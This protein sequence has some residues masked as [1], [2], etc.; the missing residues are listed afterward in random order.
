MLKVVKSW[1]T[2]T[3]PLKSKNIPYINLSKQLKVRDLVKYAQINDLQIDM[4]SLDWET[5]II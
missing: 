3:H 5:P 1:W 2:Q 4:C